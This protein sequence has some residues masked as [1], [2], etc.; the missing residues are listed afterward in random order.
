MVLREGIEPS[1][2]APS[3]QRSTKLSY[4]SKKTGGPCG[5]RSRDILLDRQVLYH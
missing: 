1:T 4:R 2:P 5:D 3:K